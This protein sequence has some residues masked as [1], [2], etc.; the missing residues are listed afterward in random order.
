MTTKPG[1]PCWSEL[2]TPDTDAAAAFYGAVAGWTAGEASEEFGGYRM[3]F[4]GDQPIAGLMPNDG[5]MGA[6]NAWTVYLATDDV[7]ATVEKGRDVGAEVV[8]GP[9]AVADLGQ[10]A[11]LV[12]PAGAA[13]G[14]WQ[15]GTFPGFLTRA[16]DGA[17][18]WFETLSKDYG[19][20]VAFYADVFGWETHTMSD[21]PEFRYTTLGKDD[22]ARAGVMDATDL[23]GEEHS[24]GSSTCRWPTPTRRSNGPWPSG[25]S[26]V[27]PVRL[28]LR[29]ARGL[30]DPAGVQLCLWGRTPGG[31]RGR[32]GSGHRP[33]PRGLELGGE[34]EQ[35]LL[36]VGAPDQLDASGRPSSATPARHGSGRVARDVPERGVRDRRLRAQGRAD[37]ADPVEHADLRRPVRD[38]RGEQ[39][40]H[41]VEDPV[42]PRRH[43]LGLPQRPVPHR[44]ASPRR[45][46]GRSRGCAARAG[47]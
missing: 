28:A 46:G 43:L 5:S 24:R 29:P 13:V 41:G 35:R 20:S 26:L 37:R 14:A 40:V 39:H 9:M 6:P 18:A 11:V 47:S 36:V 30:L 7:A 2:F 42:G 8:A 32:R 33:R 4:H 10:M 3:F 34:G 19:T 44:A 1:E 17:P 45:R 22:D 12:D 38:G 15:P 25:G 21:T 16:E 31:S 23:L 27:R